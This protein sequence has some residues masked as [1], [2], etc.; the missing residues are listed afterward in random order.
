MIKP[1]LR[2]KNNGLLGESKPPKTSRAIIGGLIGF[3]SFILVTTSFFFNESHL[4]NGD[5]HILQKTVIILLSPGMLFLRI[6]YLNGIPETISSVGLSIIFTITVFG[7]SSIP[8]TI[9]GALL[10]SK[11]KIGIAVTFFISYVILL[12]IGLPIWNFVWTP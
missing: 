4:F 6:I 12:I 2:Q 3:L 9:I 8:F 10:G 5:L 7:I 1:L 11:N